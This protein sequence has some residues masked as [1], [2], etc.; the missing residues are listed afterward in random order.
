M[1]GDIILNVC[2]FVCVCVCVYRLIT[3][4]EPDCSL[5]L[6]IIFAERAD[7]NICVI[8]QNGLNKICIPK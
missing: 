1:M 2:V 6:G 5:F 4:S 7:A 8:I 3:G